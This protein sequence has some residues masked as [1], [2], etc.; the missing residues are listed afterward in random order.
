MERSYFMK[1]DNRQQSYTTPKKPAKSRR[2]ILIITLVC[3]LV[4]LITLIVLREKPTFDKQIA[5]NQ[6]NAVLDNF[7]KESSDN[8][9]ITK[10]LHN[11]VAIH[12]D[13]VYAENNDY[14]AICTVTAP[15]I[16]TSIEDFINTLNSSQEILYTN[17]EKNLEN[18]I[19]TASII[20]KTFNVRFTKS[21]EEWQ[22]ILSDEMINFCSGNIYDILPLIYSILEG[23]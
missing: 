18:H 5:Q 22:P 19:Q 6:L 11:N 17:I 20:K 2:V 4:F 23:A 1:A 15:D 3:I 13:S 7:H 9:Y 16:A 8:N 21:N 14:I 12:V 10:A